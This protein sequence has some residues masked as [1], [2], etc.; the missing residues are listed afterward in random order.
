MIATEP[1]S[2]ALTKGDLEQQFRNRY[3]D[4]AI[5]GWR[6]R[7]DWRFGY[8]SP[9]EYYE[10]T[11]AKLVTSDTTWL[12][13]GCGRDLF[14]T[15]KTLAAELAQRSALLVGLDPD[16]TLEENPFVHEKVLGTLDDYHTD[17]RFD[18]ITLRMV[19]E[20]IAQ[21]TVCLEQL[22]N[23]TKPGGRV[24]IYTINRWSPL[25]V[26]T[27]LL[28][29]GL[30]HPIKK[31]LWRTEE[32]DTFPVVYR[33]N[34][35]KTLRG[36]FANAGFREQSFTYLNDCRTLYRFRVGHAAELLAWRALKCIGLGYPE[37]C[38]LGVYERV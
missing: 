26:F 31:F 13:V 9:D 34:T 35:R 30:H 5:A 11:V 24:V 6:P 16:A 7:M 2:T 18:L 38:L 10:A 21:P 29:F 14:P 12:D 37:Q 25:P 32:K 27:K 19:A 28:P 36:H 15:N 22:A 8:Y 3:G 4:I 20:H 23:L 1:Q 33:M 17:R